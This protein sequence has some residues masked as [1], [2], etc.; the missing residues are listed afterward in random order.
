MRIG[1][2]GTGAMACLFAS[3]LAQLADVVLVGT[4]REQIDML[5]ANG[6]TLIELDGSETHH[7]IRATDDWYSVAPVDVA[8]VLTKSYQTAEAVER[9]SAILAPYA[10]AVTLQNG[11][12]NVEQFA[13]A[14]GDD[15]ATAATTSQGATV[16]RPGVVRHA[17]NGPIHLAYPTPL[18]K[19]LGGLLAYLRGAAF[20]LY[21]VPDID[22][23]LWS[24]VVVNAGINPLT[25]LLRQPNGFLAEDERARAVMQAAA[26]EAEAVA[27]SL[28]VELGERGDSAEK[29]LQIARAT[30]TNRSS[31]LQDIE[32]GAPTEIDAITGAIIRY[33][34]QQNVPTPIN[35]AL[36]NAILSHENVAKNTNRFDL[37]AIYS[38]I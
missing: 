16:I 17:G 38:I 7:D 19:R 24:K 2:I 20:E 8:L 32:R 13:A 28:G 37:N 5:N 33:G 15:R 27:L 25:A 10:A 6:L 36:Y 22:K 12:G 21:T 9:A 26:S 4:W 31:M 14:L 1:I 34:A 18:I 30:A 35:Q 3:R 23:L 29:T 11:L